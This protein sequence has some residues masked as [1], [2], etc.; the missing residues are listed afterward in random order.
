M[1]ISKLCNSDF[2]DV[3]AGVTGSMALGSDEM[4]SSQRDTALATVIS[5]ISVGILYIAIF[6]EVWSPLRVQITLQLAI[7]W[8]LGWATLTVGHL[9]ILSVT[10]APILIGLADNLGIHL[11]ARYSEERAAGHDFRTAMEIAARQTGPGIVTAG[12][13]VSAG[14]LRRHAGEFPGACRT[15]IYCWEW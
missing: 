7:C 6:W 14:L 9:N 3:Q 10:F 5:L 2:P 4:V 13:S 11:A 8:S 12:I 15:R 1:T